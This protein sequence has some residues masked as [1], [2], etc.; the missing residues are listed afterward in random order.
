MVHEYA[1]QDVNHSD[2]EKTDEEHK[3]ASIVRPT[4]THGIGVHLPILAP[5]A[6]LQQGEHRVL[7]GAKGVE[8]RLDVLVA[9]VVYLV[10]VQVLQLGYRTLNEDKAEHQK[11]EGQHD[12]APKHSDDGSDERIHHEAQLCEESQDPDN[13]ED[14]RDLEHTQRPHE[15]QARAAVLPDSQDNLLIY[16]LQHQEQ[17]EEVPRHVLVAEEVHLVGG[18]FRDQFARVEDQ[19]GH[20]KSGQRVACTTILE[21]RDLVVGGVNREGCVAS[22][23]RSRHRL[24]PFPTNNLCGAVRPGGLLQLFPPLEPLNARNLQ[25]A[26]QRVGGFV[27][28][29]EVQTISAS[30]T[31]RGREVSGGASPTKFLR[32]CR[33]LLSDKVVDEATSSAA[34]QRKPSRRLHVR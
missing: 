6:R 15:D 10:G 24:H 5:G 34:G 33:G 16:R 3:K 9:L 2:V 18:E 22:N 29:F 25:L 17:I 12:E 11:D 19:K 26:P 21:F 14:L 31:G 32:G 27:G 7:H 28:V 4:S 13:A 1:C 23:D 8:Q 30:Q 20:F